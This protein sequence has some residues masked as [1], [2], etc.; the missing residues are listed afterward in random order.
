MS[1]AKLAISDRTFVIAAV[2]GCVAAFVVLL[3]V[4]SGGGVR[5]V[6]IFLPEKIEQTLVFREVDGKV[7]LVGTKG[8]AQVNPNLIMRTGDFAMEITVINEDDR[9]HMMFID[10]VNV[11][12][13]V[14]LPGDTDVVTFYSKGEATFN[15]YDWLSEDRQPLGQIRAMKVTAFD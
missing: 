10:G 2:V 5:H 13:K 9:P 11:S 4:V 14:L 1:R 6:Q 12:T 15:Y 8:I 7:A 3:V